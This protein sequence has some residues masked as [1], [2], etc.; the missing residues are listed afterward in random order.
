M[1]CP[2]VEEADDAAFLWLPDLESKGQPIIQCRRL[3]GEAGGTPKPTNGGDLRLIIQR[4]SAPTSD[5]HFGF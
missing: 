1:R 5:T 4:H 3:A 2:D